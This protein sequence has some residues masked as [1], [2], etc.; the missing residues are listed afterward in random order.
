MNARQQELFERLKS[1]LDE[2]SKSSET[3]AQVN[4]LFEDF[5]F[6]FEE[7]ATDLKQTSDEETAAI[8][9]AIVLAATPI[10]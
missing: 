2:I 9:K 1:A 3:S 8:L 4:S 6:S 7:I 10:Q 5:V